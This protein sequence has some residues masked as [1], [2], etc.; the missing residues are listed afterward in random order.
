MLNWAVL[1]ISK[2]ECT[3][4]LTYVGVLWV[5]KLSGLIFK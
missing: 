2:K 3:A 1:D 4:G 5:K